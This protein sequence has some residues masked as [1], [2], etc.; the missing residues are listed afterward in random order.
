MSV[1]LP[2]SHQTEFALE[3]S[4]ASH[5]RAF[6]TRHLIEHDLAHL[7]EDV[8][9]VVSELA[10]NAIVHARTPFSV[11]LRATHGT[12]LLEVLD[13]T[14]VAPTLVVARPSDSSGRGIA[15]VQALCRDWGVNARLPTGKSVWAEFD[16]DGAA[17]R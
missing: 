3:A 9:L 10:T 4:S 6:V 1:P 7:V 17:G 8:E 2:W 5:A 14:R 11:T 12:V 16:I 15:L 13:G